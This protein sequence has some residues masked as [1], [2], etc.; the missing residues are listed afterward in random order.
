MSVI[1]A[2]TVRNHPNS[3]SPR[4]K[5]LNYL[6]NIMAKIEAIDAGVAEAIMLN[7][8]GNIA[9]CTGDNIF[10]VREGRLFT[11]PIAA[12]ILAGWRGDTLVL[13]AAGQGGQAW[14]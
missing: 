8:Q 7:E 9:E 10:I 11:P 2:S 14:R 12:G 5:S 13:P 4:I 3:L 1:I 6:N